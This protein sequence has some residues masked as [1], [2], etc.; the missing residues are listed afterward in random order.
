MKAS[1]DPSRHPGAARKVLEGMPAGVNG[2]RWKDG[3]LVARRARTEEKLRENDEPTAP[4][5]N[6]PYAGR[7][8]RALTRNGEQ[9]IR[10][11]NKL[12][13][14]T[15]TISPRARELHNRAKRARGSWLAGGPRE[16]GSGAGEGRGVARRRLAS[17][18]GRRE[19]MRQQFLSPGD[20]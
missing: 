12:K 15:F 9:E 2:G 4:T 16:P 10:Q 5:E 3:A 8:N 1:A 13:D 18:G 20:E 7:K 6:P 19:K 14:G 17:G 11:T